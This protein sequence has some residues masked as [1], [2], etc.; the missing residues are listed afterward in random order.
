MQQLLELLSRAVACTRG[1]EVSRQR[2]QWMAVTG[3]RGCTSDS[4]RRWGQVVTVNVDSVLCVPGSCVRTC[5]VKAGSRGC[6]R[7]SM[8]GSQ[9]QEAGGRTGLGSGRGPGC[10]QAGLASGC[11]GSTC[12]LDCLSVPH[13]ISDPNAP[14]GAGPDARCPGATSQGRQG[15]WGRGEGWG[16]ECD[17]YRQD[18]GAGKVPKLSHVM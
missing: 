15:Q 4:R 2:G 3:P 9:R 14:P 6:S 10:A 16:N 12:S 11:G 17:Y 13:H 8:R 5:L 7:R 1:E 18:G